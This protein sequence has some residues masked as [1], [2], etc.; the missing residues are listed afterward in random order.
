MLVL[1]MLNIPLLL[2]HDITVVVAVTAPTF[3]AAAAELLKPN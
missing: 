3:A 2:L 1:L